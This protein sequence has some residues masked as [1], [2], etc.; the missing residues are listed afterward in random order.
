[1]KKA[2]F[3]VILAIVL[4]LS[5]FKNTYS[6]GAFDCVF[7]SFGLGGCKAPSLQSNPCE[8]GFSPDYSHCRQFNTQVA[9]EA[10]NSITCIANEGPSEE[11]NIQT[12]TA[13]NVFCDGGT[14]IR[15]AIGC[16][17]INNQNALIGFILRWAIG[18]G[19]GI[20]FLLILVAGFQIITSTGD[21]K[22]LQ[23]GQE[24]LTSAI[25]GLIL[26]ITSIFILRVIGVD[27]LNIQGF[28]T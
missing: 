2:L 8:S 21:P 9:C 5:S 10:Q 15:T 28:S 18:I 11:L 24:L 17:P 14:H 6:Q 1:M 7:D 27:I 22:K 13:S 12:G 4:T 26:L 19:G 25:G 16:I 3:V 23:A 20:A